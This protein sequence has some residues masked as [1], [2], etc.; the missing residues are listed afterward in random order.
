MGEFPNKATQFS[1]EYQPK[2]NGR[3]P[4]IYTQLKELGFSKADVIA[5][6]KELAFYT[7]A[8]M[9]EV[10]D[11]P[12]KP[13][14]ARIVSQAFMNAKEKGDYKIIREI[15][16]VMLTGSSVGDTKIQINFMESF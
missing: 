2:K 8:D 1:S 15:M 6:F 13:M 4:R 5:A 16:D 14:I 11:D 7:E 10:L 12:E 3:K 9:R